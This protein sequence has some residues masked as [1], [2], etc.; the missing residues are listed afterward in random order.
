MP[1]PVV[2]G[3]YRFTDIFFEWHKALP[4]IEDVSPLKAMIAYDALVHPEHPLR[5]HRTDGIELF[6]ARLLFSSAQVEYIRYWLHAV[7]LTKKLIPIPSSE[8]MIKLS[9][10]R[11]CSPAVYSNAAAFKKA[12]KQLDKA[13]KRLKGSQPRLTARRLG[14]ERI[15]AF[16]GE[17]SGTWLAIDFEAWEMDHSMITEFGWSLLRWE[18][19]KEVRDRGHLIIQERRQYYNHNYIQGNRDRYNFGD[20]ENVDKRTFRERIHKLMTDHLTKGPLYLVFHDPS[21]DVKYLHSKDIDA[22]LSGLSFV[23]PETTPKEGLYV[24]D[25]AEMFAGLEGESGGNTRGLERMAR[26][27]GS[28]V[29]NEHNAG[30]DAHYTLEALESMAS[31][32]PIDAQREKRWP[33]RLSAT[34]PKVVFKPTDEDS[35]LTDGDDVN[36]IDVRPTDDPYMQLDDDDDANL[37]GKF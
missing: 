30:N 35:D 26:L 8:Y 2:L 17:K 12:F 37:W 7:G 13:N 3:Y 4:E 11:S 27:L 32:D 14:F 36:A 6:V 18:D 28:Y 9:D 16:W 23:L 15:R 29:E 25:T 24:V 21:Q 22:P 10:L 19:G 34:Q 1:P 31:G 5:K 33:E 20:S